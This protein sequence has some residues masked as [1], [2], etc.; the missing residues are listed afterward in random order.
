MDDMSLPV[1]PPAVRPSV[2]HD[3]QQRSDDDLTHIY[4]N[5]IKYNN[6]LTEKV[7]NPETSSK[8]IED[9]TDILQH[10]IAMVV[11]NKIKGVAPMAQRSGRPLQC[12][13]GRINHKT[14]IRGNL[15][16]KRVDYSARSVITGDP[17]LSIKQLGVPIK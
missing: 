16:G 15:M 5:I 4:M 17:G 3:G 14:G 8:I 7:S 13:M 11:N 9:W 10:S 2:K 12:I 6:I 1:P